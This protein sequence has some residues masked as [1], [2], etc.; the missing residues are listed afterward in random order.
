MTQ[1]RV[2]ELM[3]KRY[4]IPAVVNGRETTVFLQPVRR[5]SAVDLPQTPEYDSMHFLCT[6]PAGLLLKMGDEVKTKE[7][8]YAVKRTYPYFFGGEE[9]YV[10][11]VLQVLAPDA[12]VDIS[13]NRNGVR[14]ADADSYSVNTVQ[15]SRAV[16]AWGE[17]EPV[18]TA[19]GAIQY[20]ITLCNVRPAAG[21]DLNTLADFTLIVQGQGQ[22]TVYFGCRWKK[23]S[24][25]GG[26]GC[27]LGQ[28]MELTAA[29]RTQ[30][31]DGEADG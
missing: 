14:V 27:K 17:Q 7:H 5:S 6:G 15:Q 10:W 3:L 13:L 22:K 12:Q 8:S 1:R 26:S 4:G 18:R 21:V 9:V 19:G 11:A 20:D 24:D 31:K 2:I 16:A 29:S 23:I 28:T 30:G 25:E